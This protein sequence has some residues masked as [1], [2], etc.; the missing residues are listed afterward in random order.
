MLNKLHKFS[1][2]FIPA[3]QEDHTFSHIMSMANEIAAQ[4]PQGL[5]ELVRALLRPLQAE[6]MLAVA[7]LK[8]HASPNAIKDF[9]FFFPLNQIAQSTDFYLRD[10]PEMWVDLAKDIVLPTPWERTRYSSA[11]ATVGSGKSQGTWRQDSNHCIALWLPWCIGFVG[12]GNHSITAGILM[13]EGKLMATDVFDLTPI[14]NRVRCDGKIY[15]EIGTDRNL[16]K[17]HDPR[18]AAVFEIG[19]LMAATGFKSCL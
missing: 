19:R 18:R 7:E 14:F 3:S 13:G 8:P 2:K 10:K 12:G 11:L 17:V 5:R 16:G 4:S 6:H 15:R 9:D 1:M